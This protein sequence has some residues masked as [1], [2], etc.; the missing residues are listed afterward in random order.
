MQIFSIGGEEKR[1]KTYVHVLG[2]MHN[3]AL[4]YEDYHLAS[5]FLKSSSS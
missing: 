4:D 2:P 5:F 1:V 3:D